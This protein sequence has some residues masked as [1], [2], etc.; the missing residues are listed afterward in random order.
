MD[1]NQV[2][3]TDVSSRPLGVAYYTFY[4]DAGNKE[5]YTASLKNVLLITNPELQIGE[6]GAFV[7]ATGY[8]YYEESSGGKLREVPK[9]ISFPDE[10]RKLRKLEK[11][12]LKGR[13]ESLMADVERLNREALSLQRKAGVLDSV[14]KKLEELLQ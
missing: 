11:H 10:T 2:K 14:Q 1:K 5:G 8:E 3:A 4:R 6:N 13:V 9:N 12:E 7:E